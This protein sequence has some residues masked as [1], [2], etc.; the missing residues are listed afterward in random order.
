MLHFIVGNTAAGCCRRPM[1]LG[2]PVY[3]NAGR[4]VSDRRK[5]DATGQVASR[6]W[7][8]LTD[9]SVVQP[10]VDGQNGH[11]NLRGD[12]PACTPGRRPLT[13]THSK[14]AVRVYEDYTN[15]RSCADPIRFTSL[16]PLFSKGA[17]R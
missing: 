5:I 15:G 11:L 17:T 1:Q 13:R 8:T 16:L 7:P 6:Q 14:G 10:A 2:F 4:M 3:G 9:D 12:D